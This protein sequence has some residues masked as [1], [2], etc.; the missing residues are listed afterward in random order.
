[1]A[2]DPLWAVMDRVLATSNGYY[3]YIVPWES[4][5]AVPAKVLVV[6]SPA[7]LT[8]PGDSVLDDSLILAILDL[9]GG[10]CV[11]LLTVEIPLLHCRELGHERPT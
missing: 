3:A 7:E 5:L 6:V 1:M 10:G 9:P 2:D 11:S 4:H 8:A